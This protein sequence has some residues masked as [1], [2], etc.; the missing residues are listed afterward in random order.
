MKTPLS[1][2]ER[3]KMKQEALVENLTEATERDGSDAQAARPNVSFAEAFRFWVK[4]GFISFGGPAGQIAIM[5]RELVERRRWLSEERFLHALN[6]CMLLPGPEAQQLAIYI[7]WLLHRTLGGL[8]AGA[9]FV[10]PSIFVLL[11]LSYIY[12]AYGNVPAVAGILAGF[13]PIV[14]AIVVEAILKIGSRALKGSAH[15]VIATLAFVAIYFLHIPFPLIVLAA[16]IIGFAGHRVF[17]GLFA[18][19]RVLKPTQTSGPKAPSKVTHAE[20]AS[21]STVIDDQAPPPAHTLPSGRRALKVAIAGVGLWLLPFLAL[22]AW[23]GW[24]SLHVQEYRFFTQA[25]LVTFGG[26]YAVLAYVTQAAAGSYGWISH[27]QAIDGLALAETTPGPLIM[28]L[29]FIGFMAGWNNPGMMGQTASA[30][31]GALVTTYTTFLP[32][33]IFIFLGAPY[34]EVLRGNK[35]LNSALSGVTA[36]VVGVI[37]NLALVFGLAVI[38]PRGLQGE[39]NW[40][41][42]VMS[43]AAFIALYRLKVDVLWVV[44]AG[45]LIGLGRIVLFG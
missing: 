3:R 42:A 8:I 7:G 14:V 30:V 5:H 33:F 35:N 15:F 28:V 10:I 4:L 32:C 25:A 6:Y 2:Q 40:F 45:G 21:S 37:L 29:Q 36:A 17:P 24:G 13:K 9:F 31:T 27:T 1:N 34:I 20:T 12:A 41:A 23:R 16:G 19:R 38:W 18:A 11:A 43:L 26:A 22:I 39:T 44:L